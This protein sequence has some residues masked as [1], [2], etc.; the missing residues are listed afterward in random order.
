MKTA[1]SEL[2]RREREVATLLAQGLTNRQ[3]AEKLF[4]A[5]RTAEHHVEQ[6]RY[7]LGFHTRSQ[8]AVWAATAVQVKREESAH[9]TAP[10][11]SVPSERPRITPTWR[12]TPVIA[13]LAAIVIAGTVLAYVPQLRQS[14]LP[15]A[16]LVD[17][18]VRLDGTTGEVIGKGATSVHGSELAIGG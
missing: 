18:V 1:T 9:I 11:P 4:I 12:R 7:K 10:A 15:N 13:A 14:A 16:T 17:A 6:I 5:E 8:V 3:I 2:T